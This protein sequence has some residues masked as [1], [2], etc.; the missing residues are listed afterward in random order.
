MKIG[1]WITVAVIAAALRLPQLEIRPMHGDE[2]VM[3]VK[4]GALAFGGEGSAYDPTG[5]HG[6]LLGWMARP[7]L[8]LSG[9]TSL[10]DTDE[11]HF[12]IVTAVC[13]IL[14]CLTPLLLA[15]GLGTNGA[16]IAGLLLAVSPAFVYWSR[17]YIQEVPLV[18]ATALC[19]G[20]G[21]RFSRS[22]S[23]GWLWG[24]AVSAG[25]MLC[26]KETAW[27][28]FIAGGVG[29]AVVKPARVW[30]GRHWTRLL[31]P[32][33][34]TLAIPALVLGPSSLLAPIHYWK[35]GLTGG[36]HAH[37]WHWYFSAVLLKKNGALESVLLWLSLDVA[38]HLFRRTPWRLQINR[39]LA[40]L[41]CVWTFG[42]CVIYTL[43]PYKTPWSIL[44]VLL[45]GML[46]GGVTLASIPSGWR[47]WARSHPGWGGPTPDWV[48]LAVLAGF[49]CVL[50]F[51]AWRVSVLIPADRRNPFVYAQPVED[52]RRLGSLVRKIAA[53]HPKGREM[54]VAVQTGNPW[55]LPWELR[56]FP[57]VGYWAPGDP[58]AQ[59][60][61]RMAAVR[62]SPAEAGSQGLMF[63]IRPGEIVVVEADPGLLRRALARD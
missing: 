34:V 60:G 46:L 56:A 24:A 48:A 29:L 28:S 37:P 62:I 32:G 20:C 9:A 14:L 40:G 17:F 42:L 22:R 57:N 61:F 55:P 6:T 45:G 30:I 39:H 41:V 18:L 15:D 33:A 5:Y 10:A 53:V 35:L 43:L 63:G 1:R 23:S 49:L 13:G 7:V 25:L 54:V 19:V 26:L 11:R 4:A 21:W 8:M 3:A 27:L 38:V 47:R 36:D 50:G 44:S 59:R 31:W 16:L 58:E 52:V 2:A 12:R 51:H